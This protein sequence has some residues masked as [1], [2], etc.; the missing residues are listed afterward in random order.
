MVAP[1][2]VKVEISGKEDELKDWA[3]ARSGMFLPLVAEIQAATSEVM[4]K[5]PR[6]VGEAANRTR[7]DPFVIAAAMHHDL[8]VITEE[9]RSS[10]GR[11]RIPRVCD[12]FGV[13]CT[14]TLGLL[15]ATGWQALPPPR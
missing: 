3:V 5:F 9:G 7:A 13:H 11:P 8:I 1:D 15:R 14:N 12:A 2:E 10:T 6:L 4:Q